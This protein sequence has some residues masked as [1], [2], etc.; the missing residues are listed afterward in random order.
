MA[1]ERTDPESRQTLIRRLRD[2]GV[3]EPQIEEAE[4]GDRFTTLA[5][6]V[7][8]GGHGAH[9][10]T[11]V[12]RASGVSLPVLREMLQ[13]VGRPN[14][15]PGTRCF[16]DEDVELAKIVRALL[17]AGLPR[18]EIIEV[19]R[20]IGQSTSQIA[21]ALRQLVGDAL[22]KRGDSEEALAL[23]YAQA[24]DDLAP[25]IP[26]LLHV[27]VRAHLRDG[28]HRELISDA[29]RQDGK[30]ADTREV[31]VAF[32]DL[33]G[34][35]ELGNTLASDALGSIAGRFGEIATKALRRPVRL[36]KMVGDA[37]MFV[38]PDTPALV[39][40]LVDL[41]GEVTACEDLPPVRVGVT[42]GPATERAGDW[43]G[44]TVNLASRI[45]NSAKRGQLLATEPVVDATGDDAW[46]R[47]RRLKL[48]GFDGRVRVFSRRFDAVPSA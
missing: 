45:T 27:L 18:K 44:A 10:L 48:K 22:L 7:A 13:A 20:V 47:H 36:V 32:A 38:S 40:T 12:G 6:E 19:A 17:D 14:P 29:E 34:Y 33:A 35:T 3:P 39:D 41:H 15:P 30:L 42:F 24:A 46:K 8:L 31:A 4:A 16:T 2:A 25:L 21:E 11:A 43:Y 9:S 5:V 28:L 37:A 26:A 1:G 23:R